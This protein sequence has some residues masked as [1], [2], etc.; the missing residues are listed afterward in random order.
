MTSTI[1]TG[2]DDGHN[3]QPPVSELLRSTPAIPIAQLFS[4]VDRLPESSIHS[5]VTLLWP[6]S[7]STKTLSA[8]LAEPDFRLRRTNGQVKVFFHGHV[9]EEVARTQIGI[10]DT[11]YLSL[12]G[13]RLAKNDADAMTQAA[14]RSVSW[15]VHFEASAFLEIWRDSKLLSTVKVDRSSNTPPPGEDVAATPSTPTAIGGARV[16]APSGSTSWPSPAFLGRSPFSFAF[17]D[18]AINPF[19]EEDGYVPGKGRKR[20][21]FSI[22]SSEWRVV[23]EPESPGDRELPEDWVA[24]FDEELET[25]SE[26]GRETVVRDTEGSTT[27]QSHAAVPQTAPAADT[28]ATM[29]DT[30]PG[31]PSLMTDKPSD[32]TTNDALFVRPT[33]TPR[34][35]S[36]PTEPVSLD[37]ASPLP[38]D[39]PR[40]HP[41]PSPGL[42]H[43]SPLPNT[44]NIPSEYFGSAIVI[45]AAAQSIIPAAVNSD[46]LAEPDGSTSLPLAKP[47]VQSSTFAST[48]SEKSG[49]DGPDILQQ[50]QSHDRSSA[51]APTE[52][53]EGTGL[54]DPDNAPQVQAH[55][56]PTRRDKDDVVTV[57]TDNMQIL[58]SNRLS[59]LNQADATPSP[60]PSNRNVATV[61]GIDLDETEG[62]PGPSAIGFAKTNIPE[63]QSEE[64]GSEPEQQSETDEVDAAGISGNESGVGEEDGASDA[65]LPERLGQDDEVGQKQVFADQTEEEGLANARG[66]ENNDKPGAEMECSRKML[67][68]RSYN[69][70]FGDDDD[71]DGSGEDASNQGEYEG[72]YGDDEDDDRDGE[73]H[74]YSESEIESDYEESLP[75]AAPKNTE[76]EVIVLDSD[77]ENELAASR[78]NDTVN[79]QA[80]DTLSESSYDS[81]DQSRSGDDL[82]D[83]AD[84]EHRRA[85]DQEGEDNM[86]FS[87]RRAVHEMEEEPE[88]SDDEDESNQP[89]ADERPAERWHSQPE[90][91]E[92]DP[93][94]GLS[95]LNERDFHMQP[96]MK[97]DSRSA[98]TTLGPNQNVSVNE[99][100][101]AHDYYEDV[102]MVTEYP[103]APNHDSLDYLAAV[104]ESA[105]R[106]HA[107]VSQSA[108]PAH[109]LAIDPSLY[110]L[111]SPQGL[112]MKEPD[113]GEFPG[114]S[115]VEDRKGAA[116]ESTRS[117]HERHLAL[118]L[119]GAASGVIADSTEICVSAHETWQMSTLGP[120]QSVAADQAPASDGASSPIETSEDMLPSPSLTQDNLLKLGIEDLPRTSTA[121]EIAD[122]LES[123]S[124]S[125]IVADVPVIKSE[126]SEPEPPMVVVHNDIPASPGENQRLQA[127]IEVDN[128]SEDS[129]DD[130]SHIPV[131][132]RYSGLRSKLSYFAPLATL[133][134]HYG[135]LVD[136]ISI[137]SEVNPPTKAGSGSKDFIITL[138]L[139]DP[140]MAGA[141]VYAQIL[142][143]YK[144]A[145]PTPREGDALLLRNFRVKSLNHSVILVSGST[146]AWAVFSPSAEDPEI[147]GPP[148]EYGVE[149]KNYVTD[150]RQ[151]YMEDGVAMVADYQLQASVGRES[152]AETPT[153]NLAHSEAGSIDMALREARGDTSSSRGSRRR[154]SHRRITIHE[155]RDGRRY[156]EVGST[157]GEESIHEL[158]DGTVYANL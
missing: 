126:G 54:G 108:Q 118:R 79:A 97:V 67:P 154:K 115:S 51:P 30:S 127:S 36:E 138:Q 100:V 29:V 4:D 77:S 3:N 136:T 16:F 20:P 49:L 55:G 50:V 6:Y 133:I 106:L 56:E 48:G 38:T 32:Q 101:T 142:R 93:H 80:Q 152:R 104:S 40:L 132:R 157:P 35:V 12:A 10:G 41:V 128:Q 95:N 94:D 11:V 151:W 113:A 131:D 98:E 155:L 47:H 130:T 158:R 124:P 39:T 87:D 84:R 27:P 1:N 134:D 125:P 44:S 8:L 57:Y 17:T 22:P 70:V 82:Y 68:N 13:S 143:P 25:G 89:I 119:D 145:L 141:S 105:E 59:P 5:V 146:S 46:E 2:V 86:E 73:S 76:S 15:D 43:P 71:D 31:L 28:D 18:S 14:G 85:E 58:P 52:P 92:E 96:N 91:T 107:A 140:S 64:S 78:P 111:G 53:E 83:E 45:A 61:K 81:G 26:T 135:A 66:I 75:E 150:L 102:H 19:V 60:Q 63:A 139:T 117:I 114:E 34:C 112:N 156:T 147:A 23:D 42:P 62:E 9:A 72:D 103:P 37:Q 99:F 33:V 137:A 116:T 65:R 129:V 123:E 122:A 149:E 24:M 69:Y 109:D 153:S 7:S 144:S 90:R 110:E 120:S 148:V 74:E 88:I 21:R 121:G